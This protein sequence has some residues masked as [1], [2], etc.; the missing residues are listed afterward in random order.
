MPMV[1]D[2]LRRTSLRDQA[3]AVLRKA[4]VVGE[5][6]PGVVYSAASLA[7]DFGVSTSP[8]REA[9]LALVDE[10]LLETV[11]NRG[12][13]VVAISERDL[14]EIFEL[15]MMLEVQ[16]VGR[17]AEVGLGERLER[18]Q[19]L[20]D[21]IEK[22]AREGDVV[23]NLQADRDFHIALME[24]TGNRRLAGTVARLRDQTR[25]YNLHTLAADGRLNDS[26]AEHRPLLEAVARGDREQAEELMR[27][28]LAHV[29]G[30]WST[31][32]LP[33]S[34]IA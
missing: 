11:P 23:A 34:D 28:H 10:G 27:R 3:L 16:G 21:V 19:L 31:D 25:L 24:A 26:A 13:R 18:L 14:A 2:T 12:F 1:R 30:D 32:A 20:V 4:L 17:A 5:L 8:V 15:R 29:P 7:K 33:A 9:M 6:A 22:T